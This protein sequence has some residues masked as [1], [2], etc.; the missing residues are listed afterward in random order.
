MKINTYSNRKDI[1]TY[2]SN[3]GIWNWVAVF[4]TYKMGDKIGRGLTK[5]YA[6]YELLECKGENRI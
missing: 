4:K 5:K 1:I 6:I 2:R 3:I